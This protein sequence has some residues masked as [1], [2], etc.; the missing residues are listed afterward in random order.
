MKKFWQLLL[1]LLPLAAQAQRISHTFS[2]VSLADALVTIDKMSDD[3]QV[4]F[5]Y[6]DLEDYRVSCDISNKS[7]PDAVHTLVGFYPMHIEMGD[8]RI[9]VECTQRYQHKLMGRLVDTSGRAVSYANIVLLSPTDSMRLTSGVS[10]E[11]GRFTVPCQEARALVRISHVG[12][13]TLWRQMELKDVGTLRLQPATHQLQAVDVQRGGTATGRDV[14][15]D[16]GRY[17]SDIRERVWQMDLPPFRLSTAPKAFADSGAVILAKY[18]EFNILNQNN[19]WAFASGMFGVLG[20]V[21]SSIAYN[22]FPHSSELCRVRVLLNSIEGVR[23]WS[24]LGVFSQD[25]HL[26]EAQRSVIGIRIEKPD[27]S[28]CEVN[29]DDVVAAINQKKPWAG[30]GKPLA[31]DGLQ[32]GDVLDVFYF[33]ED[34]LKDL[35]SGSF[36]IDFAADE[37]TLDM[38]YRVSLMPVYNTDFD[39]RNLLTTR[40]G[41]D[42]HGNRLYG[43]HTRWN[44]SATQPD[45]RRLQVN[46]WRG[47]HGQKQK[48]KKRKELR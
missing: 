33:N 32:V 39:T 13:K 46:Y 24:S 7:V 41:T 29:V 36:A 40:R 8:G 10:N 3:W 22:N 43:M 16:Y 45:A 17:A 25:M 44:G 38:T 2:D 31:I 34:M 26:P 1:T 15:D 14:Q 30:T 19:N 5:V 9:F 28:Q 4:S 20:A 12:Y 42:R 21:G 48:E 18:A 6:D 35:R 37:P 47:K 23:R 27:G 11:N